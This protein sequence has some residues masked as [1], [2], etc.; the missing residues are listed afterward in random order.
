MRKTASFTNVPEF[1][2]NMTAFYFHTTVATDCTITLP[3]EFCG[4]QI[5]VIVRRKFADSGQKQLLDEIIAEQG[6]PRTCT[7]PASLSENFPKLWENETELEEFLER[8]KY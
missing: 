5:D 8:R 4:D 3:P 2:N 6:G 7:N 1:D